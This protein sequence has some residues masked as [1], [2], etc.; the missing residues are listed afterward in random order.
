MAKPADSDQPLHPAGEA[1]APHGGEPAPQAGP[2]HHG[3]IA[4]FGALAL[5]L[6]FVAA[7]GAGM[8]GG[9]RSEDADEPA[10]L[11]GQGNAYGPQKRA[12]KAEQRVQ[13]EAE[14]LE[15]KAHQRELREQLRQQHG[16]VG[17]LVEPEALTEQ[18]GTVA[19]QTSADGTMVY[20]LEMAAGTI[21]LDVGPP[22][23]WGEHHP[24][25]PLVGQTVTVR[26]LQ[27]AGSDQFAVFAVG[28]QVI[29]G[30]GRPPWAGGW[31]PDSQKAP[32]TSPSPV[33]ATSPSP[34]P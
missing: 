3:L 16:L 2:D 24:L 20:V 9:T 32:T 13:R 7:L 22:R 27:L 8:A 4:F 28:D 5:I 30:P 14:R 17:P 25:A 31:R 19:A 1:T 15:R 6:L 34:T 12:E 33:P 29:R 26:G 23:Y 10:A 11:P 18:T 21:V